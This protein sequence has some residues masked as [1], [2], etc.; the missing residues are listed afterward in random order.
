MVSFSYP[1]PTL[2]ER[3]HGSLA[4]LG[5]AVHRRTALMVAEGQRPHPRRANW[6]G[7]GVEDTADDHAIGE[8][9]EIVII[10]LAGR[11][12]GRCA[13]EGQVILI[14]LTERER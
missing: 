5:I 13:F 14:H 11:A 7:I 2:G 8:Y 6:P 1:P 3:K 12:R 4:R 10:P 9:V